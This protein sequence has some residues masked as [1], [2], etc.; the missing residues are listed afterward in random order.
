MADKE[1][2]NVQ[3]FVEYDSSVTTRQELATTKENVAYA[4]SKVKKWYPSLV[5]TGG[6]SGQILEWNSSGTAK[7]VNKPIDSD[8]KVKQT[9]STDSNYH[10]LLI[11]YPNSST[12]GFTPTDVTEQA[13]TN[14]NL[15]VKPDTGTFY[16]AGYFRTDITSQTLNLNTI[17]LSDG[18]THIKRYIERTD[19]GSNNISNMP[20]TGKPFLLEV[21]LI[22]WASAS[23]YI[24]RQL[25]T[26]ANNPANQYVRYCTSGTWSAWTTRVFTDTKVTS[27]GNHYAPADDAS[28]II[29]KDAS[30]L[31]PAT[32]GTTS[33]VTGVDVKR[34]AKGHVVDIALDSIQ[35]PANPVPSNNVTGSGTSG[36]LTKWNGTNTITNGPQLGS[37][38]TTFLRNDGT[39]ATPT[40]TTYGL[41][42]AY[43]ASNNT[44]VTTLTAGGTGTTSTVPTASTSVYGITKLY[45]GV[46]STN[47]GLAATANAVKTAYDKGN[48]SH[49]YLPLA[50]GT[51]TGTITHAT[52]VVAINLRQD[53]ATSD[54]HWYNTIMTQTSGDEAVV[55]ANANARTSWMFVNGEDS[56]AHPESARWQSLTPALQIKGGCVAIGKLIPHGTTPT[57]KLDV[58]GDTT[59]SG[60]LMLTNATDAAGTA[61]NKPA[62][63]VGGTDTTGHLELDSN[64]IMAKSNGVTPAALYI[65]DNGGTVYVNS[66]V[67]AKLTST[68]TSGQI[69]IADGTDGNIK[70]SGYTIA[71]SVLSTSKL[72]DENVK[73]TVTTSSNTSYRPLL[74]GASWFNSGGAPTTVTDG[75]YAS[76]NCY[77]K[78][79]TGSLYTNLY[80][81]IK[82]DYT[83][84]SSNTDAWSSIGVGLTSGSLLKVIRTNGTNTYPTWMGWSYSSGLAFGGGDTKGVISIKYNG[85]AVMFASG[86]NRSDTDANKKPQWYFGLTGTTATTYNLDSMNAYSFSTVVTDGPDAS[87]YTDYGILFSEDP[88]TSEHN[89]ARK[90]NDFRVRLSNGTAS[91]EGYVELVL[92]N[93]K[94]A[95]TAGNKGAK[96]SMYSAGGG[97]AQI[98]YTSTTANNTFYLPNKTAGSYTFA[99]TSDLSGYLPTSGG[100]ISSGT[101]GSQLTIERTGSSNNA[102]IGFKNASGILGYI[103][104]D[105]VDGNLYRFKSDK[106]TYY[107]ILD[108][109]N[110]SYTQTVAS[111]ATG[112]YQ[113]GKIKINNSE[114]TIYGV[115]TKVTQ[116]AIT[117][118]SATVRALVVAK[119]TATTTEGLDKFYNAARITLL[120]GTTSTTGI[121][122]FDIGNPTK[123]GVADNVSG[124]IWLYSDGSA[125]A[126][127]K[128]ATQDSWS[129]FQFPAKGTGTFTIATTADIPAAFPNTGTNTNPVY[130][131]NGAPSACNKAAS[132]VYHTFVPSVDSSGVMEIG[133]YI[134]FH[135]K[136]SNV[137]Y[138]LRLSEEST[139]V[140]A[141]KNTAPTFRVHSTGHTNAALELWREGDNYTDYRI[142]NTGGQ[143][144]IQSDYIEGTGHVDWFDMLHLE[145]STGNANI[146]G[147]VNATGGTL[148][149]NLTLYNSSNG[150]SPALIFQRGT[151]I[152]SYN[153]WKIYDNLGYLRFDYSK[154]PSSGTTPLWKSQFILN[155]AGM[156]YNKADAGSTESWYE[157][158]H[159]GNSPAF[160]AI[161]QRSVFFNTTAGWRRIFEIPTTSDGYAINDIQIFIRRHYNNNAPESFSVHIVNNY[162][163]PDIYVI[164]AM[165]R[166]R[167]F[168]DIRVTKTSDGKKQYVEV[169]Y[170]S[171]KSN[172]LTIQYN[173][174]VPISLTDETVNNYK[175]VY[176]TDGAIIPVVSDSPTEMRKITIPSNVTQSNLQYDS[177]STYWGMTLPNG[178]NSGW[179]RTTQSGIIPYQAGAAGSGSCYIGTS[180]WYFKAAYVDDVYGTSFHGTASTANALNLMDVNEIRFGNPFSTEHDIYFGY[181]WAGGVKSAVISRYRFWNGGGNANDGDG[182]ALAGINAS[183]AEFT[184][185]VTLTAATSGA[186]TPTSSLILRNSTNYKEGISCDTRDYECVALWGS[187]KYT[188]LRWKAGLDMSSATY[189]TMQN[190]TPDFEV[191]RKSENGVDVLHCKVGGTEVS[192]VGHTHNYVPN[193]AGG[194]IDVINLLSVGNDQPAITDY[195]ISQY[196][197]GST[198]PSDDPNYY[199]KDYYYRRPLSALWSTFRE[200]ITISTSGSG[201]AVTSVNISNDGNNRKITFTKGSTFLTSLP[202]HNHDDRYVKL[203]GAGTITSGTLQI[204]GNVSDKPLIVRGIDGQNGSGTLDNLYLNYNAQ[205]PIYFCGTTYYISADGSSYNGNAATASKLGTSNVG[206]SN[207]PIYLN[208]GVAT[209]CSTPV[210]GT[211]WDGVPYIGTNGVMEIGRYIDFHSTTATDADY[212]IRMDASTGGMMVMQSTNKTNSK[213]DV[214]LRLYSSKADNSAL[215]LWRDGNNHTDYRI[216]NNNGQFRIQ[217][218][219]TEGTGIVDWYDMLH[220]AYSTGN[221]T[222]KGTVTAPGFIG[223]ATT[224]GARWEAISQGQKWSRLY[225]VWGVNGYEGTSGILSITA[226][227]G[228]TVYNATFLITSSH[229]G[230]NFVHCTEIDSCNYTQIKVRTVCKLDGTYYFEIY[231]T[232]SSIAA[233]TTQ[234]WHCCFIPLAATNIT[235]YT[236][237]TDGTT[238]PSG[239]T[240]SNEFTTTGHQAAA[241]IKNISRSGTTFTATRQDGSTFTFDQRDT[242][243]TQTVTTNDN[244]SFRPILVGSSY[245]N[246]GGAP[247]TVND[248]VLASHRCYIQPNTGDI[249]LYSPSGDSPGLIFKRGSNTDNLSDWKVYDK[250]GYLYFAR[251]V[252]DSSV[253]TD[254]IHFDG[255]NIYS[256]TNLVLTTGG[257]TISTSSY[258]TQLTINR[259]GSANYAV[260]GFQNSNG[261]LG[262]IG[263]SG[264]ANGG[265]YRGNTDKNTFY[266][267][268]DSSNYSSY[269]LPASTKYAGSPTAGGGAAEMITRLANG[270]DATSSTK[271]A[272]WFGATID[273]ATDASN[274]ARRNGNATLTFSNGTTTAGGW[275]RLSLG[276]NK[277]TG[278]AGNM[279][280][281]IW[282]Y[283]ANTSYH[284]I[285]PA[286]TTSAITH[287]LPAKT[288]TILNT[289]TTSFTRTLSTG[290]K[291]G[292]LT[293]NDVSTDIFCETN[294]NTDVNVTQTPTTSS[295]TSFRGLLLGASWW[296]GSG[297]PSNITST[298]MA[299]HN[300]YV[301]PS[302]GYM[303]VNRLTCYDTTEALRCEGNV[304]FTRDK[305]AGI[306]LREHPTYQAGVSYDSNGNECIA[307]WA[308]AGQ[309]S[310][311]WKSGIDCTY[312]RNTLM[313]HTPDFEVTRATGSGTS[314]SATVL[315]LANQTST[316]AVASI[317]TGNLTA[318]RTIYLPN[319]SG[320]IGIINSLYDNTSGTTSLAITDS[321]QYL[322]YI[323]TIKSDTIGSNL[324]FGPLNVIVWKNHVTT[325]ASQTYNSFT[326]TT[327]NDVGV[328]PSSGTYYSWT[329]YISCVYDSSDGKTTLVPYTAGAG[330]S[331]TSTSVTAVAKGSLVGTLTMKITKVIGVSI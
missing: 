59:I 75:S 220:L 124:W 214:T 279:K 84:T 174:I 185:N 204:N 246:E 117:P 131:V 203:S 147:T 154:P 303:Y 51:M 172:Q 150:D 311:R 48:H 93:N 54:T 126:K 76:H 132:G 312:P 143:F 155:E 31:T 192:L 13:Y 146:K 263:M 79:D 168:T 151:L 58:A 15:Y 74:I 7:W 30:S 308:K 196:A 317:T 265:L 273:D 178:A 266:Q 104:M 55:F 62:L 292:T 293:I 271:Y 133:S 108:T 9:P 35:I 222:F 66:K 68:P 95:T 219:Y 201:N 296:D 71:Q 286:S 284:S 141:L 24:T 94:N 33:L 14:T 144:K 34:D 63:I 125:G 318:N 81:D 156:Y 235:T 163:T 2:N 231:D 3:L 295:N 298:V 326:I 121:A 275:A 142:I 304:F 239:Y 315:K 232:A 194:L 109:G 182:G 110:T 88:N 270:A 241:A 137:D 233:G 102:A 53:D 111:S 42:G 247:S 134:D 230:S 86:I 166:T 197:Q 45:D 177:V 274:Y 323:V 267:I 78:P 236:S 118:T 228:S 217:S 39:W 261:M 64:E 331:Y 193:T 245:F 159:A 301:A 149:D 191:V 46:D 328:G 130:W 282:L 234:K 97:W 47:T 248:G 160:K 205:K 210:S 16:A 309:T 60:T 19:G 302:T 70:T 206:A 36:Y 254:Y 18:N 175:A 169:Y 105:T 244:T 211:W 209:Q 310:L 140:L 11:G 306:I 327:A 325:G 148:T 52:N 89:L 307:L 329:G 198:L 176:P 213:E 313:T 184:G 152:D 87:S 123:S 229:A 22:R 80:N 138:D 257:G 181:K 183:T 202:S 188:A 65:N 40:N 25:F 221:A 113:I 319:S 115:D 250:S 4:L 49:P 227:R 243:V 50:G 187:H 173:F 285:E 294:T 300:C 218:D 252:T 278:T 170:N 195:Y 240:A 167:L 69:L 190:T 260:I 127:I 90:T 161:T 116:T 1:F 157:Y 20:I 17:T 165:Q 199:R 43:G 305:N 322:Y 26:N 91:A 262:Y 316:P 153:D 224:T 287:T 164:H 223:N 272:I 96:F 32:W 28:S 264:T 98:I 10:P 29:S 106:N 92:G 249:T 112:A 57:T 135:A 12:K 83:L 288:G 207:R 77:I 179:I 281:E 324:Y 290:T 269:A 67:V 321:S 212:S 85:P 268:L 27:V 225:Y 145:Y 237:F 256:G 158:L 136:T 99:M 100:T 8:Y 72:T 251:N 283:S 128:S 255:S 297:G 171:D 23:D 122:E 41:S 38:T 82:I 56:I 238:I 21:E 259:S 280:S 277:A 253:W 291:I 215:E 276:N 5:P 314:G 73:Q 216:I 120:N 330:I 61:N 37:S 299:S 208:A 242:N 162:S 44:W 6:S 107:S 320:T 101:F 103:A 114:T 258:A 226:T 189:N 119:S 180:T 129:T 289:G 200:L 186:Q 139:S